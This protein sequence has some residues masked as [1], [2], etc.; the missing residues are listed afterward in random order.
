MHI[1]VA[2][3]WGKGG[4]SKDVYKNKSRP[5]RD[6]VSKTKKGRWISLQQKNVPRVSAQSINVDWLLTRKGTREQSKHIG[7]RSLSSRQLLWPP[8]SSCLSLEHRTFWSLPTLQRVQLTPWYCCRRRG[9]MCDLYCMEPE[10]VKS[11]HKPEA[12]FAL[13]GVYTLLLPCLGL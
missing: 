5:W 11:W 2:I 1:R 13:N 6:N 9:V 10:V 3:W 4:R 12:K 7:G 8:P